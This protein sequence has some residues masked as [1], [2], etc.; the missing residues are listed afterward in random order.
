MRAWGERLREE[1]KRLGIS[2]RGLCEIAGISQPSQVS[3]E[4]GGGNPPGEYWQALAEHGFDVQYIFSGNRSENLPGRPIPMEQVTVEQL[5][6]TLEM[7]Q[8]SAKRARQMV[9]ILLKRE[10]GK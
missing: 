4:K 8:E 2:Q 1:R 6:D 9:K 10:D 7:L 3:Y 5:E